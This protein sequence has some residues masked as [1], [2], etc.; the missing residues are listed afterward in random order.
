MSVISPFLCNMYFV[1][2][3]SYLNFLPGIL[4][5]ISIMTARSLNGCR[6]CNSFLRREF[7]LALLDTVSPFLVMINLI[8]INLKNN[9]GHSAINTFYSRLDMKEMLYF[10]HLVAA[11]KGHIPCKHLDRVNIFYS[12]I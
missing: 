2:V 4:S 7:L 12:N 1:S 6:G 11:I 5:S 3:E 9:S 8:K 10:C